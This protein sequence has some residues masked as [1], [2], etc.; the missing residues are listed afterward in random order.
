MKFLVENIGVH[1]HDSTIGNS[2]LHMTSK[3]EAIKLKL[4]KLDFTKIRYSCPLNDT[5]KQ[6]ATSR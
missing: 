6:V 1:H 2:F 5:F 3:A 4:Y